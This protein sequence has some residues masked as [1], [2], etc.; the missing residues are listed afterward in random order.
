VAVAVTA[1]LLAVAASNAST[2]PLPESQGLRKAVTVAGIRDHQSALQAIANNNNGIRT[3]GT[4]GF[5][6]S[7]QYVYD[8]LLAAG[9]SPSFQEFSFLFVGDR[10]PPVFQQVSP[11]PAFVDGVDFATMQYS[12]SGDVTAT[13]TAV[14]P[15]VPAPGP[16]ATTS[17]CE[18]SDFAGFPVGSIALMQ[19]GTCSFRI[20]ATNALAA[21][22]SAAVIFNDGGDASRQGVLSGTFNP[23]PPS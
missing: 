9:Y 1:S 15:V 8:K 21:G 12:G 3:S 6:A 23:R 7:A 19:R 18:A 22:A 10:T 20:K 11:N 13:L 5:D 14:D 17:G 2:F 4:A 16:G